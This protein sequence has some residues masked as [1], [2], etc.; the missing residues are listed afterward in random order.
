MRL[1]PVSSLVSLPGLTAVRVKRLLKHV[2]RLLGREGADGD[3]VGPGAAVLLWLA[4]LLAVRNYVD[5]DAQDCLIYSLADRLVPAGDEVGGAIEARAPVPALQV[6]V[7][8][9]TFASMTGLNEFLDLRSGEMVAKLPKRGLELV[10]CDLAALYV[11]HTEQADA[12]KRRS[13][14]CPP[15][16]SP[17]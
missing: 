9:G 12:K 16:T 1:F 5:R 17:P 7:V 14:A 3:D 6:M 10:A 15:N 4:S 2:R 11:M 13:E 8:D